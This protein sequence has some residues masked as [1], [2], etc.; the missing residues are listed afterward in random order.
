MTSPKLRLQPAFVVAACAAAGLCFAARGQQRPGETPPAEKVRE[1]V[2]DGT[3]RE[4]AEPDELTPQ[5]LAAA[6]AEAEAELD[7]GVPAQPAQVMEVPAA[8]TN[9]VA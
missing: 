8:A 5:D 9:A 1:P 3:G 6:V 2:E 4:P 7:G